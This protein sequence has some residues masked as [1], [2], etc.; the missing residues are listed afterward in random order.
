MSRRMVLMKT[1][2]CE[3]SSFIQKKTKVN[4]IKAKMKETNERESPLENSR[5]I[6]IEESRKVPNNVINRMTWNSPLD[7]VIEIFNME[8]SNDPTLHMA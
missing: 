5:Y 4:K 3:I 8:I 7:C 2:Y 1:T 6:Y